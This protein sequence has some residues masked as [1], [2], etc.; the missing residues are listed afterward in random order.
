MIRR[1]STAALLGLLGLV[2][3]SHSAAA[4]GHARGTYTYNGTTGYWTYPATTTA[5]PCASNTCPQ[6]AAVTY[7]PCPTST[8]PQQTT[9]Y[10]PG[11]SQPTY[12]Y[13]PQAAYAVPSTQV[14]AP[15]APR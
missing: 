6:P 13:A 1:I 2:G 9:V 11:Y 8:C 14:Y 3:L 10:S 12:Y 4:N 15:A 7:A 5:A